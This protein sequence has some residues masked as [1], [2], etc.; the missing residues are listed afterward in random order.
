MPYYLRDGQ[1][2]VDILFTNWFEIFD[3]SYIQYNY[4]IFTKLSKSKNMKEMYK[5]IA[6]IFNPLIFK[7]WGLECWSDVPV[8]VRRAFEVGSIYVRTI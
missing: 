5:R 2:L 8:K 6:G 1:P 3:D 4:R 7:H